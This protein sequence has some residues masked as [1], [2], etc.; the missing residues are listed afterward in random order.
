MR[1]RQRVATSARRHEIK[2]AITQKSL[3]IGHLCGRLGKQ[4]SEKNRKT[5]SALWI[6]CVA[7]KVVGR[8][9]LNLLPSF[10][11][12][13]I[14]SARFHQNWVI[15]TDLFS[16]GHTFAATRTFAKGD[17][18]MEATGCGLEIRFHRPVSSN[19]DSASDVL[20]QISR[21]TFV[22]GLDRQ[23]IIP[24]TGLHR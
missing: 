22:T 15:P 6:S 24:C 10:F 5:F 9:D 19:S 7:T 3:E 16:V 23:R 11:R 21:P 18:A 2:V 4:V 1:R 20:N 13:N 8:Q 14:V 12:L 17:T